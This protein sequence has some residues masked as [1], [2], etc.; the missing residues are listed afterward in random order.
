MGRTKHFSNRDRR[1]SK[2]RLGSNQ[3]VVDQQQETEPANNST[4]PDFNQAVEGGS[5]KAEQPHSGGPQGMTGEARQCYKRRFRPGTVALREIRKLQKSWNLLIPRAPFI[6]IVRDITCFYSKEVNR[7]QAEALTA[8]Q[9]AAEA[10]LV[11][12]FDNANLCA[13]HAKR[14]TLI[15]VEEACRDLFENQNRPRTL[16]RAM[17]RRSPDERRRIKASYRAVYGEELVEVL[18]RVKEANPERASVVWAVAMDDGA[19][20]AR[21]RG[22]EGRRRAGRRR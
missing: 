11:E 13:I 15:T 19:A 6:R 12:L 5:N 4:A 20:G 10:F 21:R 9:E 14:V 1:R 16:I 3:S 8:I 18:R 22:R 17:A 2:R 7:W